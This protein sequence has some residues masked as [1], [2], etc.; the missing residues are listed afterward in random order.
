LKFFGIRERGDP[1]EIEAQGRFSHD[2]GFLLVDREFR[3]IGKWPLAEARSEQAVELDPDLYDRLKQDMHA[4]I[5][6]ELDEPGNPEPT[7]D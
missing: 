5:R 6:K 2:L 4:R 1:L 7:D 3:V